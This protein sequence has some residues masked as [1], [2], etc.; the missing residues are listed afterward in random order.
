MVAGRGALRTRCVKNSVDGGAG[1]LEQLGEFGDGVH[2][3]LE[4]DRQQASRGEALALNAAGEP[5]EDDELDPL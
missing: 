2:A 4:L 1:D 5:D 3:G